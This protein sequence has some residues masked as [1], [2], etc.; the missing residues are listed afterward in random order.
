MIVNHIIESIFIYF[1]RWQVLLLK[2]FALYF[3]ITVSG[4][5]STYEGGLLD[6]NKLDEDVDLSA[7]ALA[8]KEAK[9]YKLK[10]AHELLR[11]LPKKKRSGRRQGR[12]FM[13]TITDGIF[14]SVGEF[15]AE[16]ASPDEIQ[17]FI[18]EMEELA[19]IIEENEVTQQ[20]DSASDT[21]ESCN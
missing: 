6:F 2:I 8:Q 16:D 1:Q 7:L 5:D 18:A 15:F 21:E 12:F 19:S 3:C 11:K 10:V 20:A 13:D 9:V 17:Q 14:N 4:A